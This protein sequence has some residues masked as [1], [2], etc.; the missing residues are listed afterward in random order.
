MP[1]IVLHRGGQIH[2][3]EVNE[4]TNLVVR[5]GIK[6]FPYPNLRYGCGMGECAKC[7]SRIIDGAEHLPA[8]NWKEKKQLGA[9]LEEGYRLVC[10]LWL[11]HDLE[12]AQDDKP[13]E[14]LAPASP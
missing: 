12:L 2:R 14:P 7:A 10:Q 9:K 1:T 5:A 4:N 3:G 13:L 6:Q 11:S 8:P